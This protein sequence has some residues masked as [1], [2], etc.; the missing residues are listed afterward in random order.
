M[1][2]EENIPCFCWFS[3]SG[4]PP[5]AWGREQPVTSLA[6]ARGSTPTC[7]GKSSPLLH[8]GRRLAVHPHVRGEETVESLV[9]PIGEGPPPRAWGRDLRAAAR[10][11]NVRSTPTCVG[12]SVAGGKR[13]AM[14]RVHPHVRG[15]ESG[16]CTSLASPR[17]PPPRAWGR[18]ECAH[19][20]ARRP[21]STPT[22][23]GKRSPAGPP[24]VVPAVHPHVRGEES[25]GPYLWRAILGPPPR[26]WGRVIVRI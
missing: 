3:S 6:E 22:C 24:R 15:E 17:G 1:R 10:R 20:G 25:D 14:E 19:R 13:L 8:G 2:G 7:V 12:K 26:A 5:R 18:A 23:V 9:N 16:R 21:G 4:P 11:W